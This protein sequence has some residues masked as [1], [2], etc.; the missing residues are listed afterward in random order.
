[1]LQR[2]QTIFLVLASVG[3]SIGF[4]S[5]F[6]NVMTRAEG[7]GKTGNLEI[8]G[9][10]YNYLSDD[11]TLTLQ[12][13][14]YQIVLLFIAGFS[15]VILLLAIF[16]FRNRVLQIRLCGLAAI[17]ALGF[18]AA[19]SILG[20]R[21]ID[22]EIASSISSGRPGIASITCLISL[23]FI[24]LARFYIKKDEALVRSADRIR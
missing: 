12:N 18:L 19:N 20:Y 13:E 21:I 15:I 5:P 22:E 16:Q 10:I 2:I 11:G 24:L 14:N 23:V 7:A 1:M 3:L 9:G 4:F 6:A 8:S 17:L